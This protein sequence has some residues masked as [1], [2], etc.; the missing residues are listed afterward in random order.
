MRKVRRSLG[1]DATG[2][3]DEMQ[4]TPLH[5]LDRD[6]TLPR[7]A[8]VVSIGLPV[9]NGASLM[10]RAI[11]SVLMQDFADLELIICD[12]ASIDDTPVVAAEYAATDQRVR[13]VRRE[14]NSAPLE[15]FGHVLSLARGE[16]FSWIAHDDSYDRPDHVT[17]LVE[18]IR[19]GNTLAF[20]EVHVVYFDEGGTIVRSDRNTLAAFG[21][22]TG[23]RQLLRLAIRRPSVQ[24]YGLFRTEKLREHVHLMFA[25][26][27]MRCFFEGRFIQTVLMHE[28][29][30]FVPE[31][32]LNVGQHAANVS[33]QSEPRRLLRDYLLYSARML[34][35]YRKSP[36]FTASE[37]LIIYAEIARAH[38]PHAARLLASVVKR[39]LP[40]RAPLPR[41]S[42]P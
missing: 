22:I 31:A 1:A 33:G 34:K 17:R 19:E 3:N 14:R 15:N 39:A 37:R 12:N 23:R 18:K 8:P 2:G 32:M 13:Y 41:P 28:P 7:S 24:I 10:R 40:L 30:A 29:W 38:G 20:P 26:Q 42:E 9:F 27:D 4:E 11:E 16:M 25:D 35:M 6:M 21:E 36:R 5:M